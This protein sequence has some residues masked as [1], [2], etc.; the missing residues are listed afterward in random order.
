VVLHY[1]VQLKGGH[2]IVWIGGDIESPQTSASDIIGIQLLGV[3]SGGGTIHLEGINVS[4]YLMDGIEGGEYASK[5]VSSGTL[6]D[7]ILQIENVRV[8]PIT[9]SSLSGNHGD[10]IQQ[11][12]GW[13]D[14]RVDHFTCQSDFQGFYFP[15]EDEATNNQGVLSYWDVRNANLSDSVN[16]DF[17]TLIHFGDKNGLFN[18]TTHQQG[19]NLL[20]VYLNATQRTFN[21]ETYPNS[22][23]TSS[24][25]TVVHSTI[26]SDGTATWS[27]TWSIPGHVTPG[28]PPGGDY[29]PPGV[30]GLNYISP[31]YQ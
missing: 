4:G 21:S 5:S 10:C 30:A 23:T 1:P 20:N 3:G 28:V 31:G 16:A 7:A 15:W 25:G 17:Q 22:G 12:G 18:A 8:G 11:Y 24:D 19:G 13:K 27:N 2:N 6:A 9:G 29:V 26:N 14:L